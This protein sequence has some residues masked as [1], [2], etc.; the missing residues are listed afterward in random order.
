[1]S[2]SLLK[3]FL[4]RL[5]GGD[6]SD[7]QW[8]LG[9]K[10]VESGAP[11][12]TM[13]LT[14]EA[15]EE[16]IKALR[17]AG[18]ND[19]CGR[20]PMPVCDHEVKF[21]QDFVNAFAQA[22]LFKE[23]GCDDIGS[24]VGY[25]NGSKSPNEKDKPFQSYFKFPEDS[26]SDDE[27]DDEPQE[28]LPDGYESD[29]GNTDERN[30]V[31]AALVTAGMDKDRA[32]Y[33]TAQALPHRYFLCYNDYYHDFLVDGNGPAQAN[34]EAKKWARRVCSGKQGPGEGN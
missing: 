18:N 27:D 7:G 22:L 5:C 26:D 14:K 33:V 15:T 8:F 4:V 23:A 25:E 11:Y 20:F 9:R 10:G 19:E 32:K 3:E 6:V 1:M 12:G 16:L 24:D 29:S 34:Y 30:M 17:K 13:Q 28:D 2:F 21:A 31:Y